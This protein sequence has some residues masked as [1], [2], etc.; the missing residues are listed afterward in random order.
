MKKEEEEN[1]A[2]NKERK[3]KEE[4]VTFFFNFFFFNGHFGESHVRFFCFSSKSSPPIRIEFEF[5]GV[6]DGESFLLLVDTHR[7]AKKRLP[8][9]V[10]SSLNRYF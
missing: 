2:L 1:C 7:A 3:K 8:K 5:V 10:L 9:V 4:A 6:C